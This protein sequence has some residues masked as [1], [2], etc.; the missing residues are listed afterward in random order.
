MLEYRLNLPQSLGFRGFSPYLQMDIR[1]PLRGR[2][3]TPKTGVIAFKT[4]IQVLRRLTQF[5]LP[6]ISP[7]GRMGQKLK[8]V[9]S[10]SYT[11]IRFSFLTSLSEG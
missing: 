2:A 7:S 3:M 11:L 5:C 9:Y 8:T 1:V 10:F 6:T 4:S